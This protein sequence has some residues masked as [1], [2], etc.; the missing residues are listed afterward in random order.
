MVLLEADDR[1]STGQSIDRLD[2]Q[3]TCLVTDPEAAALTVHE[4]A[5]DEGRRIR[6]ADTSG[7]RHGITRR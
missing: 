6:G 3:L 5:R 1:A 4:G 2:T 7:P